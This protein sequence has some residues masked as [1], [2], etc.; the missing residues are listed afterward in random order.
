MAHW[1]KRTRLQA[2]QFEWEKEPQLDYFAVRPDSTQAV[3]DSANTISDTR[4]CFRSIAADVEKSGL[5][6]DA[7]LRCLRA[8]A[9][10]K[11]PLESVRVSP[12]TAPGFR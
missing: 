12:R 3:Q 5:A 7:T 10:T 2:V 8:G 1:D 4:E 9:V 6:I 11:T